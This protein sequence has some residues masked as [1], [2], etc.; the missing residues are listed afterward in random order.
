M[1][2]V[3]VDN[4]IISSDRKI[5]L[6]QRGATEK[7]FPLCWGFVGGWMEEGELPIESLKR[8]A[9]EEI[10]VET[11]NHQFIGKVFSNIMQNG[12]TRIV[13]PYLA[14]VP[15]EVEFKSQKGEVENIKWFDFE[16]AIKLN[17]AH[18]HK[19]VFNFALES[20]VINKYIGD[21]VDTIIGDWNKFLDK[22]FLNLK[23]VKIDVDKFELDHIAYRATTE[24][25]FVKLSNELV[26]VARKINRNTIRDRFVDAY[27]FNEPLIYRG[28]DICFFELM[29][30]AEGDQFNEGLEHIEFI[31]DKDLHDFVKNY[32]SLKWNVNAIDRP[33]GADV[34]IYFEN[35]ANIKFKTMSMPS[36]IRLEKATNHVW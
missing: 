36:I 12:I 26:N 6:I 34:G 22:I 24:K 21:K 1:P 7:V 3:G 20:G 4:L 25:S 19:E 18:D 29:A 8:E 13:L 11:E 33:I 10:G 5:L 9:M 28:R 17:W 14:S 2:K 16:E 27:Q 15:S 35:G 32:P 30:P 23:S 31:V